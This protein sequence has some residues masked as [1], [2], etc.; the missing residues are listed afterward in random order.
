MKEGQRHPQFCFKRQNRA[1]TKHITSRGTDTH[2]QMNEYEKI[3]PKANG[4][5]M[6]LAMAICCSVFRMCTQKL[7]KK[8]INNELK[9][10]SILFFFSFSM[11]YTLVQ[12]SPFSVQRV[13]HTI[14]I[15]SILIL[16]FHLQS[17]R[18]KSRLFESPIDSIHFEKR[19]NIKYTRFY[20]LLH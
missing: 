9:F 11:L 15:C 18:E 8:K 13:H 4:S 14:F 5:E 6:K 19:R 2:N 16:L 17:H 20:H 1:K 12:L 10:L 3:N 7:K